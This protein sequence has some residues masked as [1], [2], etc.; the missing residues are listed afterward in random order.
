MRRANESS[1][2]RA[3]HHLSEARAAYGIL[4]FIMRHTYVLIAILG[5]CFAAAGQ[6]A[7]QQPKPKAP[8]TAATPAQPQPPSD[9]ELMAKTA[10][11]RSIGTINHYRAQRWT[12]C[13]LRKTR[14]NG[15]PVM[16]YRVKVSGAPKNKFYTL[17]AW[18]ITLAAPVTMMDGLVIASDGTVGC[19]PDSDQ[20]LRS[21]HERR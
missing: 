15:K 14:L 1:R 2:S 18:P 10:R 20:E 17:M 13:S 8:A 11:P 16:Q 5:V 12:C 3:Q 9:E 21:A 6:A 4:Q 7:K 19:P